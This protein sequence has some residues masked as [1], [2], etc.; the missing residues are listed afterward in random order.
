MIRSEALLTCV[1]F[2]LSCGGSAREPTSP[3]PER[4]VSETETQRMGTTNA[5]AR[6]FCELGLVGDSVECRF[7]SESL[8]LPHG[9]Q[10]DLLEVNE[11]DRR[12]LHLV[13]RGP[14]DAEQSTIVELGDAYDL[15]GES[16]SHE[17]GSLT[18]VEDGRL[19]LRYT[20]IVQTDHAARTEDVVSC[21]F[22]G[23]AWVCVRGA[24]D[25]ELL[26]R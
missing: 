19:D 14:G 18:L 20:T 25:S 4:D 21:T 6:A 16:I 17:I 23:E 8:E 12:Y 15:P 24:A 1:A 2:L 11:G 5:D 3:Q 22:N 13:I 10:A 7:R 26:A 9:F